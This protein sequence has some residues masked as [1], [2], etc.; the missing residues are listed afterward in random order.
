MSN[1]QVLGELYLKLGFAGFIIIAF[2]STFTIMIWK[3][4]KTQEKIYKVLYEDNTNNL[5]LQSTFDIIEAQY[6]LTKYTLVDTIMRI[7]FEN[8][9]KNPTRQALIKN[10]LEIISKNLYDRDIT[11]LSKLK[12]KSMYLHEYMEKHMNY[13]EIANELYLNL[14]NGYE[15]KDIVNMLNNEYNTYINETR[16]YIEKNAK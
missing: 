4:I 16:R 1:I 6:Q 8:N 10:N 3:L 12:Y 9:I 5:S 2:M 7:H 13:L 15:P 11:V 14:I